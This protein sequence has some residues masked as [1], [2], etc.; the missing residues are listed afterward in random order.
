MGDMPLELEPTPKHCFA[1]L[2]SGSSVNTDIHALPLAT[3]FYSLC[4]YV[5]PSC[6]IG[7]HDL[8][9]QAHRLVRR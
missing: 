9:V 7:E 4:R 1:E 2:S 3:V 6:S 5:S 8:R